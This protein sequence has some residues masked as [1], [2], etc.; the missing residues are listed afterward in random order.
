MV[1]DRDLKS[2]GQL[3]VKEGRL[4]PE[5]L[6]KVVDLFSP[7]ELTNQSCFETFMLESLTGKKFGLLVAKFKL[8]NHNCFEVILSFLENLEILQFQSLS[9]KMY[10]HHVPIALHTVPAIADTFLNLM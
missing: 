8:Q 1:V 2:F 3:N 7:P 6:N 9:R 10:D 4:L 5:T